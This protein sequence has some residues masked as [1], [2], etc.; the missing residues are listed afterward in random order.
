MTKKLFLD[1]VERAVWTFLQAG[2]GVFVLADSFDANLDNA[3]KAAMAGL[4]A[5]IALVKGVVASRVGDTGTAAT[6]PATADPAANG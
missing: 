2:L 6:L 1:L 5:V 3:E 4:A